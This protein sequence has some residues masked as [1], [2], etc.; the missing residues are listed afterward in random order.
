[1]KRLAAAMMLAGALLG[2]PA[3]AQP[4]A[5]TA[6]VATGALSGVSTGGVSAFLGVPYAA[7]PTGP[8][9][10][11]MPQPAAAWSGVRAADHFGANCWQAITPDGFGPWTAEYVSH[12]A[13]SEDCLFANVWTPAKAGARLP[14]L[15]WIHGG[16]FNQGSGSVPV[17]DGA[18]L[19]QRGIVVVNFN[20]RMGAFGFLAHPELTREAAAHG[21]PTANYGLQDMIAALRWVKANIAAFGG[22]PDA[23]TVAGQS[24]GAMATHDLIASPLAK[25]LFRR[26]ITES[27]LPG[28]APTAP[29]AQAEQMGQAF[30]QA[31]GAANLADLRALT[32]EA[33]A[34]SPPGGAPRF[35]PVVD[36]TLLRQD[37]SQALDAGAFND[38]PILAGLNADEGSAMAAG[39]G[40]R[41]AAAYA[42]LLKRL[43]DGSA[44]RFAALYPAADDAQRAE[45]SRAV[46]RDRGLAALWDWSRHRAAHGRQPIY[47]YLFTHAEPGPQSGRYH[48]FHSAELAYVFGTLDYSLGR[49]FTPADRALSE[50]LQGYWV[51]FIKSGDPNGPGLPR[52]PRLIPTAP[53]IMR[54]DVN[55][56]PQ[57]ILSPAKRRAF[58]AFI[59]GGG[60][61]GIF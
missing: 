54:L 25:G 33:L 40:A 43:Y 26:A 2:R 6:Q 48:A 38:T 11:R 21:E 49:D 53:R 23:V 59:A 41:D 29:L 46:L 42:A 7:P 4:A 55:P 61:P 1:M 9:R 16:G 50:R 57:P 8:N 30:A 3:I 32:P 18:A 31:K 14:V 58:D 36:G 34:A 27:G 5:P 37:P 51:D 20:Y 22:D 39:Y 60:K 19:A 13:V 45:A 28:S 24:A 12:G 35:G 10:W 17:Y 44:D 52:W 56:A 47:G 15:V